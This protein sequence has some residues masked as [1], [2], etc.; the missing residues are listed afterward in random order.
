MLLDDGL[1]GHLHVSICQF[2]GWPPASGARLSLP[3]GPRQVLGS[4]PCC[5]AA[6]QEVSAVLGSEPS[7]SM[8]MGMRVSENEKE[9]EHK[10]ENENERE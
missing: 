4:P 9:H 6:L 5:P 1:S 3:R 2:S 8:V 10:L 7:R